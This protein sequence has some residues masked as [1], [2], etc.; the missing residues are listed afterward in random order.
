M[1]ILTGND[2]ASGAVVWWTGRD[3]SLD[4][5]DAVAVDGDAEAIMTREEQA[6]RVNAPYALDAEPT[7]HGP[8]PVH[9]RERIRA[10]GPTVRADLATP[11]AGAF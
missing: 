5:R 10:A 4:L 6:R 7:P 9:I 1:T 2:L 11:S 3:W 8:R